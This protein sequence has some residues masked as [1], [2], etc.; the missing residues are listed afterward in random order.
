M[1]TDRHKYRLGLFILAGLAL[2]GGV[3]FALGGNELF[4]PKFKAMTLFDESVQGLDAGSPVK[5]RGVAIGKV[6]D[7]HLRQEDNYIEV[8]MVLYLASSG[9]RTFD[10]VRQRM[11]QEIAKGAVCQLEYAGITGM[12]YIEIDYA[13]DIPR[14]PEPAPGTLP[15]GVLY[16]PASKSAL[17]SLSANV[18]NTLA[19][20][21]Q[22]DIEGIAANLSDSLAAASEVLRSEETRG[23]LTRLHAASGRL[24]TLLGDV[25]RQVG[26]QQLADT[27]RTYR[28]TA[29][30][31]RALLQT[32]QAEVQQLHLPQ[33]TEEARNAVAETRAAVRQLQTTLETYQTLAATAQEQVTAAQV[34]ETAAEARA[35]LQQ[36]TAT[37][38]SLT[39]L[40]R[41]VRLALARAADT[42]ATLDEW[43]RA[44]DA[45]PAAL[46]RGKAPAPDK[47]KQP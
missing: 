38:R 45:D 10:E 41:D 15:A 42:L 24:D 37:T 23:T 5:L 6:T 40:Q 26:E 1:A 39:D 14:T 25:Q 4:Q 43:A 44:L 36:A 29:D 11:N 27:L 17:S 46:L 12:K 9:L 21:A 8:N 16:L 47:E 13:P 31:I 32:T 20:L 30:E 18:M 33:L 7:I 2:L 35:F 28:T 34:P 3:L 22:I 19:R